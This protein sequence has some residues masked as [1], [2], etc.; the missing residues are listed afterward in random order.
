MF[1]TNIK[2]HFFFYFC[3]CL[4]H[5]VNTLVDLLKMEW[6]ILCSQMAENLLMKSVSSKLIKN[7]NEM[8]RNKTK[9]CW[10]FINQAIA[11]KI[12]PCLK[13][14]MCAVRAIIKKFKITRA[15][16]NLPGS[17]GK[18]L[19]PPHTVR[20]MVR[21]AKNFSRD[22]GCRFGKDGSILGLASL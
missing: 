15:V 14:L 19:F 21:K 1:N 6:K 11:T 5:N 17:R 9:V 13:M 18:C 22:Q 16:I 4:E 3:S 2:R 20:R 8:L 12:A 7:V 10:P